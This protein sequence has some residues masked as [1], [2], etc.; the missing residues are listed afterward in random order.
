MTMMMKMMMAIPQMFGA[1]YKLTIVLGI[2]TTKITLVARMRNKISLLVHIVCS[3]IL[4]V[5]V[6]A[7]CIFF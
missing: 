3:M 2:I 7:L 4:H 6:S 5:I 1:L